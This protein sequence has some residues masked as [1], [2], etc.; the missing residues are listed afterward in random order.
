MLR[1]TCYLE[2]ANPEEAVRD[3]TRAIDLDDRDPKGFSRRAAA[4][5]A[6]GKNKTAIEDLTQ[7]I[8]L[9]PF[10][11]D[12]LS[13][14]EAYWIEGDDHRAMAD[15]DVA[16]QLAPE[17][18]EAYVWRGR[19]R[20]DQRQWAKSLEDFNAAL[21][22]EPSNA[23]AMANA[24]RL[25]ATVPDPAIRDGNR[26]LELAARACQQSNWQDSIFLDVLA[27]AHAEL[28]HFDEAVKFQQQ[29]IDKESN[30]DLKEEFQ[31]R[32]N[33]YKKRRAYRQP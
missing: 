28:S 15:L 12:Y 8:N 9:D 4:Y 32:L 23:E 11:G 10:A 33:Q 1:G 24:A 2:E 30:A 22:R 3:L 31:A 13:R 16:I 29:A 14:A 7:A 20:F 17:S 21:D 19:V 27:A 26:A 6:L 5:R 18:A 25:L